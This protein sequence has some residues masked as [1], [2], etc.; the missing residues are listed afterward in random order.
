M[1]LKVYRQVA[2][3]VNPDVEVH[4]ALHAVGCPH[5]ATPLGWADSE[6]GVLAFLQEFLVGGTEGWESAQASVRDLFVEADLHPSDVGLGLRRRGRAAR[7]GHR[8]GAR[9]AAGGAADVG[10]RPRAG[11]EPGRRDAGPTSPTPCARC[12]RCRRTPPGWSAPTTTCW[13]WPAGGQKVDVQRVHGD[14]H[15]GQTLRTPAGWKI[16]DFEGEPARPADERR[17]LDTPLRDVAGMLRSLDYAARLVLLDHPGD[18]QR[19]YRAA[20]WVRAQLRRL[21]LGLR[22]GV[23]ARP[24]RGRGAAARAA[25]P[26]GR[27]RGGVRGA[28]ATRAGWSCR[29]PRSRGSRHERRRT[30]AWVDPVPVAELDRLV[31]GRHHE[32]H[33]VLGP[34]P[35][36][37]GIVFRVLRPW[38]RSVTVLVGDRPPPARAPARGRVVGSGCRCRRSPTTGS[39][40]TTATGRRCPTTRT[41]S[42]P[43]SA[44]STSTWSPRDGTSSCGR[45]S[46]P[47]S[48]TTPGSP[49]PVHGTAFAVWAPNAQGVRVVGDFNYWD[50]RGFPMRVL[51]V[52]RRVGAVRPRSGR[53]HAVQVRDPRPRRRLAA[54]GRPDG[55][56][57]RGA[58]G[59]RVG[60][61]AVD[62]RLGRQ[63]WLARAR[64]DR[65]AHRADER[66]RGA[67]GVVAAGPGLPRA[68][69]AARRLRPADR[70]SRTSSSCRWPSTPSAGRGAT[71]SRRTTRR[72]RGSARRTTSGSSSTGCTRP[73][74]ASSS[75]GCP[76]TSPRTRGRW[77]A[78]TARRCT[79]TPTRAAAS[80]PTGARSCSTSA[81][82]RCA[83]SWSP[84]PSTGSR[85]STS[86]GCGST[87]SRRCSTSTTRASPASGPRTC[88]AAGRTSTPS[89]S[90]RRS[91]PPS[92]SACPASS[93]SPRSRP[94]GP[95]SPSR[96]TPAASGSA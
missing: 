21:L 25:D 71:R 81:A 22:R 85:S 63:D 8:R 61:R 72:R 38:A 2:P 91:T 73:A 19:A 39:R 9:L 5:I 86:T 53:G 24:A 35:G 84:T 65:P 49:A 26:E 44:S 93:W 57:H 78:S 76:R 52:D 45:C 34:H 47:A 83:T 68:R 33:A 28:D 87:P 27:L 30:A 92:T 3:G 59:D 46:A 55:P 95:A 36:P 75:T 12:P 89:R 29:W 32:P 82:A 11:G 96:P 60:G 16:L 56:G 64:V 15:L 43:R 50:G 37:D 80:S 17:A 67:P 41:A 14:F 1:A 51:G 10:A 13:R 58:A 18:T 70:A 31:G 62:V 94:R 88:T 69:R 23:R 42:C 7:P 66:L 77:R 48:T 40:S 90:C 4:L 6:D 20:E 74:S 79:S 54:E